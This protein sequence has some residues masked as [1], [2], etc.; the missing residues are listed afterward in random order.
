M[1]RRPHIHLAGLPGEPRQCLFYR[2]YALRANKDAT[3]QPSPAEVVVP[4]ASSATHLLRPCAL[5]PQ[6]LPRHF[7]AF[8][9]SSVFLNI[10]PR[11]RR[12]FN[13]LRHC[14]L[15]IYLEI[16]MRYITPGFALG[17]TGGDVGVGVDLVD[18]YVDNRKRP[19]NRPKD[20]VGVRALYPRPSSSASPKGCFATKSLGRG[21]TAHLIKYCSWPDFVYIKK[22]EV[23][24]LIYSCRTNWRFYGYGDFAY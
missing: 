5:R 21:F 8:A 3:L 17:V 4:C 14:F 13:H 24:A 19:I 6:P 20:A 22:H 11:Q 12:P 18:G 16:K 23:G 10:S 2:G 7:P 1:P 9:R 15:G